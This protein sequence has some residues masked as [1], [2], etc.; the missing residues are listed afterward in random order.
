M[1]E[2]FFSILRN[3]DFSKIWLAQMLSQ[4]SLN[5]INFALILRIYG[6]TGSTTSVSL[7]L[8]AS[9]LPSV[10]LGPF[11]GV[12]A[13]R[14]NYKSILTYTNV[15]RFIAVLMIIFAN[16]NTLAVLEVLFVMNIITQF[17]APAESSSFPLIVKKDHL[18]HANS[19]SMSTLYAT[20]LI[21]YSIAGPLFAYLGSTIFFI[22]CAFM[23]L[24]SAFLVFN[25]S[26]YDKKN[27]RYLTLITFASDIASVWNETKEGIK[28]IFQD[29]KVLAPL[30]KMAV[31]W[32]VLGSFIVLLPGFGE[33]VL[34]IAAAHVGWSIIGPA[35]MG[36]VIGAY[37]LQRRGQR[38][39]KGLTV[40]SGF[41]FVSI[42]LLI[43]L[44]YPLYGHYNIS[45]PV[46]VAMTVAIGIGM[47]MIYI[48]SQTMLHINSEQK[49]RG[50]VFGISSMLVNLAMTV[51]AIFIG[52][53]ADFTTPLI[54]MGIIV[55]FLLSYSIYNYFSSPGFTKRSV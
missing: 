55:L 13:D 48:A 47:A 51:P 35:G 18:L 11:S 52:G 28:Y 30:I 46:M 26:D 9:A 19:F 29:K 22:I 32:M 27:V 42:G 7:V 44:L 31:G 54:T 14:L 16:G 2:G 1:T 24:I 4:L 5:M 49:L 45:I 23:Y 36:M 38:L 15:L 10:L 50:R 53:L 21:G 6:L 37:L 33:T 43:L 12:I 17:F 34:N 20:I 40:D 25:M 41:M 3:K 39:D 8:L